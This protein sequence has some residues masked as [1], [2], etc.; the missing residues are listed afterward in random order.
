MTGYLKRTRMTNKECVEHLQR[1][2]MVINLLNA[3]I[4]DTDK[5]KIDIEALE[6]AIQKLKESDE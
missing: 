5:D 1:L 4:A 6:Y 2:K 3:F